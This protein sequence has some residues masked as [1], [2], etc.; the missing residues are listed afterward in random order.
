[1]DDENGEQKTELDVQGTLRA[2]LQTQAVLEI[3]V[4]LMVAMT[5]QIA[6]ALGI[7]EKLEE[8][9]SKLDELDVEGVPW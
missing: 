8:I 2:I 4:D 5:K 7:R 9:A 6:V 1:M 3:K